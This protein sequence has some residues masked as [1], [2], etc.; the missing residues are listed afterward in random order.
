MKTIHSMMLCTSR[1]LTR[2]FIV[3][4]S[5]VFIQALFFL[6]SYFST[7]EVIDSEEVASK[8]DFWPDFIHNLSLSIF[9]GLSGGIVLV[10]NRSVDSRGRS[11]LQNVAH[12]GR[13]FLL[14]FLAFAAL[15]LFI[16]GLIYFSFQAQWLS[17]IRTSFE[18][19]LGYIT[20]PTFLVALLIWG[21]LVTVTQFMLEI[22]DR[23]GKGT[24]WKYIRGKYDKPIEET[25]IF[26]FL[27]LKG[28]S[29]IAENM[30]SGQYFEMLREIYRDITNPIILS[31]GEIYQYV[32]D[33]VVISWPLDAGIHKNNA[34]KC[35]FR[36]E[37]RITAMQSK[38]YEKYG[39]IPSFKAGMHVGKATLGEIGVIKKELVYSGDVLNTTARL[40]SLCNQYGVRILISSELM[41]L[42]KPGSNFTMKPIGEIE[43][44]GKSRKIHLTTIQEM[45]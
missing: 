7:L 10:F 29:A 4:F 38:Y 16:A 37:E 20:T 19:M 42:F 41:D 43:L 27:D 6:Y 13:L 39:V 5:W 28:S 23:F 40:Q 22:S 36:I 3:T 44:K 33:E 17:A 14:F 31:F 26:M 30:E 24:F 9:G 1:D 8:F 35:F 18:N 21:F 15:G 34:L 11:I 32:G 45:V 12:S 25:R 2:I